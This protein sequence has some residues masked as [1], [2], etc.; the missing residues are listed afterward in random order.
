MAGFSRIYVI[1]G[2]GGFEGADGVNPVLLQ[3]LLGHADRQWLEPHYF[4][5]SIR[6]LGRL[7]TIVPEKPDAPD[8]LLDAC[9][10]F[11]PRHFARCP[12]LPEVELA[13]AD[14]ERLDFNAGSHSIPK[15]WSRLR[16]EARPM[17]RELN[18]WQAD[19]VPLEQSL[20]K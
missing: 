18:I 5:P 20:Q 11:F 4:D 3:V 19:L 9:V 17:F 16:E 10:A 8:A 14:C 2:R 12:T 6:P 13:L 1:G 7:S 15:A